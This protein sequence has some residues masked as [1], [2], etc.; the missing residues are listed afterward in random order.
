MADALVLGTSSNGVRV[1]PPSPALH[2][3][4]PPD[5]STC[6]VEPFFY[7]YYLFTTFRNKQRQKENLRAINF[8]RRF[9]GFA[10]AKEGI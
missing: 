7:I 5:E 9:A 10:G 1:R 4:A 8:H 3:K 2:K 6:P